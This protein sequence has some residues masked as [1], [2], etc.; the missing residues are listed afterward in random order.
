MPIMCAE[1]N[2]HDQSDKLM[3]VMHR[4]MSQVAVTQS[5][6]EVFIP[7]LYWINLIFIV[8]ECDVSNDKLELY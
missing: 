8:P 2:Y 4:I 7:N 5:Q 3:D 1:Q 6:I